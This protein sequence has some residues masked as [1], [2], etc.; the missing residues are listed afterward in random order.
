MESG[1]FLRGRRQNVA[2]SG[3]GPNTEPVMADIARRLID[4]NHRRIVL[5]TREM[6][7]KPEPAE[8]IRAFLSEL[9]C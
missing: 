2:I 3:A 7:R 6:W 9:G 4:L 8:F 1:L 5:I